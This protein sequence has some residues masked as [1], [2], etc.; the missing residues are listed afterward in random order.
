MNERKVSEF[1][2][3]D[4]VPHSN[5]IV[6]GKKDTGKSTLLMSI[7][8]SIRNI[9]YGVIFCP[10]EGALAEYRTCF[11]ER[12]IFNKLTEKSVENQLIKIVENQEKAV[13]KLKKKLKEKG[14]PP[15]VDNTKLQ[16]YSMF[17]LMDDCNFMTKLFKTQIM[18][19]IFYNGRHKLIYFIFTCH[20]CMDVPPA[21]RMNTDY[22]FALR[23]STDAGRR[24]LHEHYFGAIDK[25]DFGKLMDKATSNFGSLVFNNRNKGSTALEQS[26]FW[27]RSPYPI[28]PFK[29]GNKEFWEKPRKKKEPEKKDTKGKLTI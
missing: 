17:I 2:L 21:L 28:K 10:S 13:E 27:Y 18:R 12:Y 14:L 19:E 1:N 16:K 3:K 23:D 5:C 22:T 29:I 11:P 25:K 15:K 20:Y 24:K 6:I 9:P 8:R 26:I 4:I 7:L